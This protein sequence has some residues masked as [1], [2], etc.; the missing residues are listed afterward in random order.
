MHLTVIKGTLPD[1]VVVGFWV[2]GHMQSVIM[3]YTELED[4]MDKEDINIL[5]DSPLGIWRADCKLKLRG[6]AW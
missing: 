3:S 4:V 6:T 1:R 5:M 2:G